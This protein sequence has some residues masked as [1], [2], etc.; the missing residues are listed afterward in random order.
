[1][2]SDKRRD[3]ELLSS[4]AHLS[5]ALMCR[6]LYGEGIERLTLVGVTGTNGKTTVT[7]LLRSILLAAGERVGSI[8]TLGCLMPN[9]DAV[10]NGKNMTT[11]DPETLYS[12]LS[13]MARAGADYAIIEASSHA[14]A[15]KKLDALHFDVGIFTNFSRDHL[16]FHKSQEE[17][18]A[19]KCRLISLCEKM[20]VNRDDEHC[21]SLQNV[22]G[23]SARK[24][25]DFFADGVE[26][27]GSY[28][29]GYRFCSEYRKFGIVS[30]IPGRFTVMNTL[31]AA[32]AATVLG[33]EPYAIKR[34]I[35]DCSSV[36]GRMERVP[37][38]GAD[39]SVYI[40]YAHTPDALENLLLTA[41][42]FA[43][44]GRVVL[45]FGCGGDRDRGKRAQMAQ[46][47]SRLADKIIITSDNSRGEDSD[48]IF[49][50]ILSGLDR[51][52]DHEIIKDRATA[53]E[54]AILSAKSA[55]VILLAG[56]GHEKYEIDA[57]GR[58]SFDEKRIAVELTEKYYSKGS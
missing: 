15:K 7:A 2:L 49:E 46:I 37:L 54:E 4:D 43:G 45:L 18:F 16:D 56:K 34:G 20:I 17:Y 22:L 50:D 26:Y 38:G 9:G 30:K 53:I 13:D 44:R 41:K 19:A 14:L 5:L 57:H 32:A 25:S 12:Q 27:Y 29:C 24:R 31:E 10:D 51:S 21:R 8:G 1:M 28:G 39:F 47:A 48:R 36:C 42:G 3:T 55:D 23:C 58:H 6:R 40:D 33:V 11:P 35:Y 52:K